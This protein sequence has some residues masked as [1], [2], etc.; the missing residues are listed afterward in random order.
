MSR[1]A[2][3]LL[4][5]PYSLIP[6][7]RIK[8]NERYE[9]KYLIDWRQRRAVEAAIAPYMTPDAYGQ[10]GAYVITS[11][12]FDSADYRA[13]WEK[14]D[15]EGFRRKVRIRTYGAQTV[16]PETP[17]FVEIKQRQNRTLTKKRVRL[18]HAQA[19]AFDD[20]DE[21]GQTLAD[22]DRAVL[23]E[24]AY[25]RHT[26]ALQPACIVRYNR[27]AYDG[28]NPYG[29]LR[30][31]FDTLLKGRIHDLTLLSTGHANDRHTL[32]PQLCIL[33]LKANTSLPFWL[34]DIVRKNRCTPQRMSKYCAT[35]EKCVSVWK[36]QRVR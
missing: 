19:V 10:S 32:S 23:E 4:P 15:G 30:V 27:V 9:L 8:T 5:T 28:V 13:Y 33:E 31:T 16:A 7:M 24:V 11:L 35:L 21:I 6:P 36:R 34:I 1:Q 12:Y 18:P 22:A 20:Y 2:D 29:D 17:V 25:L 3:F 26:Q 14:V